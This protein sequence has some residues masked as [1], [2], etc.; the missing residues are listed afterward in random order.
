MG[1]SIGEWMGKRIWRTFNRWK[2][3]DPIEK[4]IDELLAVTAFGT[5]HGS[6]AQDPHLQS[7]QLGEPAQESDRG[8]AWVRFFAQVVQ[9]R[10]PVIGPHRDDF[11]AAVGR[12][13]SFLLL[14]QR[15]DDSIHVDVPAQV[16]GFME[17]AITVPARA[18]EM[19]E[20]DP[21]AEALDH[22]RQVVV[23]EDA[24]GSGAEANPVCAGI[25]HMGHVGEVLSVLTTR[26]RPKSGMGGSSGCKARRTPDSEATGTICSRK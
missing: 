3:V 2:R 26:G 12:M 4:S 11:V 1:P 6:T 21:V 13:P 17:A 15:R 19:G 20:I 9:N 23:G 24:E 8:V 22:A 18:A 14:K 7:P 10:V 16:A 25:H 5:I